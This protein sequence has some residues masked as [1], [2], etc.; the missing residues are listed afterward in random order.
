MRVL[1]DELVD[2]GIKLRA[3]RRQGIEVRA[4]TARFTDFQVACMSRIIDPE[5]VDDLS[6]KRCSKFLESFPLSSAPK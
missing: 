4:G 5:H 2:C 3:I 1:A 6:V